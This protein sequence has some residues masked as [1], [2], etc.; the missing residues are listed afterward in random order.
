MPLPSITSGYVAILAMLYAVLAL[1]VVRLRRSNR[2]AFGDG[3]NER[4][5]CAIRAHSHFAEYVPIIALMS[6]MAEL[7]GAPSWRIH[8]LMGALLL[9]RL[10]HPLGMYARPGTSAFRIGRVGGMTITIAVMVSFAVQI[11]MSGP[12]H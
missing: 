8:F 3:G 6:A 2:A 10:L 9:A 5:R 7:S 11:L 1:Q 12:F 4:L